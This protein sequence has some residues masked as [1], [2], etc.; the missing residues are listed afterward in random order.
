LV[1]ASERCLE[2]LWVIAVQSD[3]CTSIKEI[4]DRMC[5]I[6]SA[7]SGANVAGDADLQRH[8]IANEP[9]HKAHIFT[10]MQSVTDTLGVQMVE[11]SGDGLGT[12]GLTRMCRQAEPVSTSAPVNI[13]KQVGSRLPLIA[14]Y[15][16]PHN[17]PCLELKRFIEHLVSFIGTKVS[18][19]I[20]DPKQRDPEVPFAALTSALHTLEQR[21][22]ILSPPENHAYRYKH[23]S[24]Q[25]PLRGELLHQAIGHQF[26]IVG[27]AHPLGHGLERHQESSE[28]LV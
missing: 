2:H 17:I 19:G 3:Q 11:C 6:A 25:H 1:L 24:V 13:S 8:T 7:T 18:N 27:I 12:Y 16:N 5:R 23:F 4:P 22:E 28:V 14:T 20:E 10:R 21:I 15:T 26:V 9:F